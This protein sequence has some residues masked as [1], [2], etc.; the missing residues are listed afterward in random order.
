MTINFVLNDEGLTY[1]TKEGELIKPWNE[2]YSFK[3]TKDYFFIYFNKHNGLL[4][5]KRDFSNEIIDFVIR[6][7]NDHLVNKRKIKLLKKDR[8][9]E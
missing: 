4:L 2:F 6:Q 1:K 7:I 5:A 3:E 9:Q 8:Y